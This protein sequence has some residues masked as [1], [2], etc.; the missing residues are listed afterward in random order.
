[1]RYL[2]DS[3]WLIDAATALEKDLILVTR[4]VRHFNRIAGL[5][6]YPLR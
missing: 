1:V 4:N 6:L 5:K 3:D 2:V